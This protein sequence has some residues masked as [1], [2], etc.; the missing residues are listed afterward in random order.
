[1][2]WRL[3]AKV[4]CGSL[5]ALPAVVGLTHVART[6]YVAHLGAS[7][8]AAGGIR[9]PWGRP[10]QFETVVSDDG[11]T[12]IRAWSLGPDGK[13]GS[14]DEVYG[15]YKRQPRIMKVPDPEDVP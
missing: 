9:D 5:I 14:G 4:V 2:K 1:M 11:D 13:P 15:D 3:L 10:I 7:M 12:H 6:K 8:R